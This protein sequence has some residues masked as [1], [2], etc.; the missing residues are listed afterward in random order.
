MT[1]GAPRSA[2][3]AAAAAL[4]ALLPLAGCGEEE[5]QVEVAGPDLMRMGADQVMVDLTHYLTR[6]GIRQGELRA[7]T[8]FVFS[9]S[10]VVRLRHVDV[11]FYDDRGERG[12]RLTADSGRYDLQ[13]GDMQ[14]HGDVVVRD[15]AEDERL[16]APQLIYEALSDEL[17]TDT[18]FVWR[19]GEDVLRG[20]GLITD[21]SFEDVRVQRPAGTSPAASDSA[22]RG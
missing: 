17:R 2:G 8:A 11:T 21:P 22:D 14:A 19:R 18:S 15:T 5:Q 13:T 3:G 1:P 4:L 10:S 20:T 7:D 6:D 12:S 9:D 16:E